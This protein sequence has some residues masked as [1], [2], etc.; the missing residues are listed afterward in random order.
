[1]FQECSKNVPLIYNF[2]Q[3]HSSLVLRFFRDDFMLLAIGR[4]IGRYKSLKNF[5][6]SVLGFL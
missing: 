2:N 5:F 4:Q 1:M 3:A 6:T